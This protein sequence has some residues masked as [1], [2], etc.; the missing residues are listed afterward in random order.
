[1]GGV[2]IGASMGCAPVRAPRRRG[3]L[4]VAGKQVGAGPV[5]CEGGV[6]TGIDMPVSVSLH[7]AQLVKDR[8]KWK[9]DDFAVRIDGMDV[10]PV[11][12]GRVEGDMTLSGVGHSKES[13]GAAM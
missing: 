2:E 8:G 12:R 11:K 6:L 5:E 4:K 1:M 13:V 7:N 3:L 9:I 10:D